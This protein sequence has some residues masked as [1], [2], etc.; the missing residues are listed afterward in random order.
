MEKLAQSQFKPQ[1]SRDDEKRRIEITVR[2]PTQS[3]PDDQ[4][5]KKLLGYIIFNWDH[6]GEGWMEMCNFQ[7]YLYEDNFD[8]GG[9]TKNRDRNQAGQHGEGFKIGAL[10]FRRL[11]YN[12]SVRVMASDRRMDFKF[13]KKGKLDVSV[14]KP[15][16]KIKDEQMTFFEDLSDKG[17]ARP[18]KPRI[19]EDVTWQVGIPRTVTNKFKVK[20]Q[21]SKIKLDDFL[22]WLKV[23]L[24]INPPNDFLTA[25]DGTRRANVVYTPFG[26]LILDPEHQGK[27]YVFGLLLS[28]SADSGAGLKCGY[29]YAN[30]ETDRDRKLVTSAKEQDRKLVRIWS[31]ATIL[32]ENS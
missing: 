30:A 1:Y 7:A 10:V 22:K 6:K 14:S 23:T 15:M 13:N 5:V 12:H 16:N 27:I 3:D 19:Y 11:P 18:P 26:D 29:N 28:E 20:Q 8:F 21:T 31:Y 4:S 32:I 24:D 17:Q 2:H 25:A 9:T